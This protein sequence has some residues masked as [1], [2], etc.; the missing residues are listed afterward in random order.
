MVT[1][2][3]D[4]VLSDFVHFYKT[5]AQP[6]HIRAEDDRVVY[7][8]QN[9]F[10]PLRGLRNDLLSQLS[11][12][13]SSFPGLVSDR[14]HLSPIQSHR[15]RAPEVFRGCP[16]SYSVDIWNLGLLANLSYPRLPVTTRTN[17]VG[18]CGIFWKMSAF[19]SQPAMTANM[20][21]TFI[22]P[23]WCL[24]SEIRPRKSSR[25]KEGIAE[26]A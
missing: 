15:C 4:A 20:M 10:G 13:N 11:D 7:L 1:I 9:D 26:R 16:W 19:S 21:L 12:F 24:S 18:R 14:G 8:S 23:R 6:K 2:E 3:N 22:W 17:T 25:E 5:N